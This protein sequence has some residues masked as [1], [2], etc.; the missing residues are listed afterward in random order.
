M[1][2]YLLSSYFNCAFMLFQEINVLVTKSKLNNETWNVPR[3]KN[4]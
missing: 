4:C 2:L 3:W 1:S